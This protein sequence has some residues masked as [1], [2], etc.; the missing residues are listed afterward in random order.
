MASFRR[1]RVAARTGFP[2]SH[3]VGGS[4]PENTFCLHF[5]KKNKLFL[6]SVLKGIVLNRDTIMFVIPMACWQKNLSWYN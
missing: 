2:F 5:K 6:P 4:L 1:E 3:G